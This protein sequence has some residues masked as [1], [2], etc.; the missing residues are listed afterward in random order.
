M[1]RKKSPKTRNLKINLMKW[2]MRR[3]MKKKRGKMIQK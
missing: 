3:K 1:M 2:K